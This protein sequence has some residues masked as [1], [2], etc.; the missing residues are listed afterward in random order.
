LMPIFAVFCLVEESRVLQR[1]RFLAPR[2][3]QPLVNRPSDRGRRGGV[4]GVH[5]FST[6][7]SYG[8]TDGKL[9]NCDEKCHSALRD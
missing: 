5:G 8:D 4:E 2:Y 9:D 3:A 7:Y 1:Y 6:A